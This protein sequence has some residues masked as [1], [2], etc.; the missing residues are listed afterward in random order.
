MRVATPTLAGVCLLTG[1]GLLSATAAAG[2]SVN[3]GRVNEMFQYDADVVD[4]LAGEN[5]S[6][7]NE[8]SHPSFGANPWM[9]SVSPNQNLADH[10][11][12]ID[13]S[14]DLGFGPQVEISTLP[15]AGLARRDAQA[16]LAA[17]NRLL[18]SHGSSITQNYGETWLSFQVRWQNGH[19]GLGVAN[20][21]FYTGVDSGTGAFEPVLDQAY[22]AVNVD[23]GFGVWINAS[24]QVHATTWENVNGSDPNRSTKVAAPIPNF[25]LI[26]GQPYQIFL[27]AEWG[28]NFDGHLGGDGLFTPDQFTVYVVSEMDVVDGGGDLQTAYLRDVPSATLVNN[29]ANFHI[30]SEGAMV[31]LHATGQPEVDQLRMGWLSGIEERDIRDNL[32][33]DPFRHELIATRSPHQRIALDAELGDPYVL[34]DVKLD[35]YVTRTDLGHLAE[36]VALGNMHPVYDLNQDE[37]VTAADLAF[38]GDFDLNSLAETPL[39]DGA[40]MAVWRDAFGAAGA[41]SD[42]N[43][44]S[45][46]ADLLTWQRFFEETQIIGAQPAA[47]AAPEPSAALLAAIA[48][49]IVGLGRRCGVRR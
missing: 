11:W 45:G 30:G 37:E 21:P 27:Q 34:G 41:D 46:G 42:F 39:V 7:I 35:G 9:G 12:N 38:F 28:D 31:I 33:L 4:G 13:N 36:Q 43:G 19:M 25:N 48:Y 5:G 32:L 22:D 44:V 20:A 24:G 10:G 15:L 26:P 2:I 29:I 17:V 3:G 1:L 23:E 47:S 6:G 14:G 8:D 40:D 16:G 18:A 49:S